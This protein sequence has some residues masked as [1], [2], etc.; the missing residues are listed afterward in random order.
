ML[1]WQLIFIGW[2]EAFDKEENFYTFLENKTFEL[3]ST[4]KRWR[5]WIGWALSGHFEVIE[6]RMP[7]K[8]NAKYRAWKIWF[9]KIFPY[10]R[11]EEI[12]LVGSSLGGLFLA[13]YLS[14]NT[15]PKP[16][17][18]LHLV[19]PVFD[20]SGLVG[21]TVGDFVLDPSLLPHIEEQAE[22]IHIYAST[23]DPICPFTHGQRYHQQLK[24]SVL[25]TFDNRGHFLQPALPELLTE[26]QKISGITSF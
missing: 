18:Q 7:C 11:D 9:E 20:N 15:F 8:D 26:I 23:D 3:S 5:D 2:W 13:K 19:A 24:K 21:E 10:L 4:R 17:S 16:I 14:E 12:I 1:H 25:H 6:P 22:H